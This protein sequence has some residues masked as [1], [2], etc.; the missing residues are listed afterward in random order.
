MEIQPQPEAEAICA[1]APGLRLDVRGTN[2][3][4]EQEGARLLQNIK[5]DASKMSIEL[6]LAALGT[7][8]LVLKYD[9][10]E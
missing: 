1:K 9:R 3:D 8:D 4:L 5:F 2:E 6:A 10:I 7:A